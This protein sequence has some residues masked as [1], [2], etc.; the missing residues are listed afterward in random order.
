MIVAGMRRIVLA[1]AAVTVPLAGC[2]DDSGLSRGEFQKQGNAICKQGDIQLAEKGKTLFGPDGQ[3]PPTADALAAYFRDD[4]LPVA[5]RKLDGLQQLEPPKGDR[6]TFEQM[7]AAGRRAIDRVD[8]ELKRDPVAYFSAQG[9]DPFEEF[10]R[11]A[12]D[13]GLADCADR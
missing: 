4:A 1:L 8:Q 9:P 5:R 2:G 3:A 12:I 7:L 6:K 10:N 11:L 13:L